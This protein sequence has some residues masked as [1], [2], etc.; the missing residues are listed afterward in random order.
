[1]VTAQWKDAGC[2]ENLHDGF[3]RPE[4]APPAKELVNENLVV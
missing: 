1:M 2:L 3:P 4:V